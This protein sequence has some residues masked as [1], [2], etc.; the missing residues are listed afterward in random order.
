MPR[1]QELDL[2]GKFKDKEPLFFQC[3]LTS[4]TDQYMD[5]E[6]FMAIAEGMTSLSELNTL[7]LQGDRCF[8]V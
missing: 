8:R 5:D 1:L 2:K 7:R 6:Q 4:M 3:S